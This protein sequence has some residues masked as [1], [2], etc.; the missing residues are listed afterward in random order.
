MLNSVFRE[1]VNDTCP[2]FT[3][4]QRERLI[5]SLSKMALGWAQQPNNKRA[6]FLHDARNAIARQFGVQPKTYGLKLVCSQKKSSIDQVRSEVTT[7][8]RSFVSHLS[9]I[10]EQTAPVSAEHSQGSFS[11]E[12]IEATDPLL[13]LVKARISVHGASP[14]DLRRTREH[15]SKRRA[16]LRLSSIEYEQLDLG[17]SKLSAAAT[18]A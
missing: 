17:L 16:K 15:L 18:E 10:D 1:Y 2:E 3:P 5:R 12:H 14:K 7:Y 8:L 4:E 6:Q 9:A 13:V 11:V